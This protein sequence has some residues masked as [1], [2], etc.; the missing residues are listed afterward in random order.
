MFQK[1]FFVLL[2]C[3]CGADET[4]NA[5]CDGTAYLQLS[6]EQEKISSQTRRRKTS[7]WCYTAPC[8]EIKKRCLL[9]GQC[10]SVAE[11]CVVQ[12]Q[13]TPTPLV[14]QIFADLSCQTPI[15]TVVLTASTAPQCTNCADKCHIQGNTADPEWKSMNITGP[16]SVAATNNCVGSFPSPSTFGTTATAASGCVDHGSLGVPNSFSLLISCS[17]T[18]TGQSSASFNTACSR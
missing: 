15:R 14:V 11:V 16:G 8:D 12:P 4:S 5:S 17:G 10:C 7:A 18:L 3:V 2:V 6:G 1:I 13:P 9:E